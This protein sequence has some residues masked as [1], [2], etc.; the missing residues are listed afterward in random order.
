MAMTSLLI[1]VRAVIRHITV[2]IAVRE[3]QK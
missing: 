3:K 2:W 1:I